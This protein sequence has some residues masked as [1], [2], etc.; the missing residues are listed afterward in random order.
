MSKTENERSNKCRK[1]VTGEEDSLLCNGC[2]HWSHRQCLGLPMKTYQ[3]LSKSQGSWYC[4][5]CKNE[6]SCK[7]PQQ[8][9][10]KNYTRNDVMTKLEEI[11]K[12][13]NSLF[14]QY[15]EQITI[16]EKL[17]REVGILKTQI[18]KNEQKELNNNIIIRKPGYWRMRYF[19]I[20]LMGL[21]IFIHVVTREGCRGGGVYVT[22][23]V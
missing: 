12:K 9:S 16:N 5:I 10:P 20:N 4:K 13:Y 18:N 21:I 2:L 14:K 6:E 23:N 3:K 19:F 17:R 11:D 22:G 15:S 1:P 8:Q 7:P